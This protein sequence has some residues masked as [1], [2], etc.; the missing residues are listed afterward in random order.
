[1]YATRN[2]LIKRFSLDEVEELESMHED[3]QTATMTALRDASE[4]MNSYI[5][6]K[7]SIP[8]PHVPQHITVLCCNIARY[9]LY[10]FRPTEE[11]E[12]RYEDAIKSLKDISK[13][14]AI[15]NFSS[16]LTPTQEATLDKTQKPVTVPIRST[17]A[18]AFASKKTRYR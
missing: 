6:V 2:D 12:K 15:L 5:A 3:G 13:G 17:F 1:M 16:D 18:D 14:N 7:Y 11:V 8:L 10:N 4:E 9:R